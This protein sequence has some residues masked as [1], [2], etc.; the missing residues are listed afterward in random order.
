[1]DERGRG[2]A[3]WMRL[4]AAA[5]GIVLVLAV[6]VVPALGGPR[7]TRLLTPTTADECF[8]TMSKSGAPRNLLDARPAW[9][10]TSSAYGWGCRFRTTVSDN[11]TS[12]RYGP[13]W[14]IW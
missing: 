7:P 6:V 13:W 4:A 9:V 8:A 14:A 5:A 11:G 1:M 10:A 2:V 3:R 12:I